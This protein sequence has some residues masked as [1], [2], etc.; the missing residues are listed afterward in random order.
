MRRQGTPVSREALYEEVWTDAVTVVA[1]RYGLSDVGL[2]KI[3]K[4]L[5]IP[6]PPRGYWAK[7]KAGRPTRKVP[8]PALPAEVR[9]LAGPIP[10]SEHE[11]AMHARIRDAHQQ[12]RES[13]ASI[14]VPAELVD[15]H[16]LVRA[17][18]ARLK[19]R[20]GWDHPAGVRSAPKEVVD[21]QVTRNTLDRALR[22][23]DT[24]LKALEP[25]GFTA[26]IDEEKGQTLLVGGGTTLTI[27]IVEQVARSSHTPTR[28]EVRARDR[29]Y[30]SFRVGTRVEYPNIPQFDWHPT[31]RLTLA[32]GSW[33]SRKWNDTERSLMDS[34]L[35]GIVAAIIGLAEAKRAKEE[36]EERRKQA[37][38][39]ARARYEAQVRARNEERR[40]L[41]ALFHGASRLQRA[42]RLREFIAA[43]EDRARHD[44]ELT[45]ERQQWIDWARAKADWIDPLVRRSDPILDAPEPEAPRYWLF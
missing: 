11:A 29:Y 42:N 34:R 36:E 28:A 27:S 30:D 32:V 10:L 20:D 40:Q 23:T 33:P 19:R 35:S 18:A 38:E 13:L 15:P 16:P 41:R 3:C 44:G 14:S 39:E 37:Y 4:K 8:L 24:L 12:N 2:V 43:V 6:V 26:A 22:L 5:G 31:G 7:V 45:A 25:I 17:A 9:D 21:L 1:P